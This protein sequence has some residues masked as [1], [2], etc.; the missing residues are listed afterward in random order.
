MTAVILA[1]GRGHRLRAVTGDQPKC[2]A[3]VGVRTL[4]ARQIDLIRGAGIDDIVIVAGYAYGEV[5]AAE[6]RRAQLI[7]NTRHA[8][9]NSLYSLWLARHR[10]SAGFV[11]FNCDVLLHPTLLDDL[12]TCRHD[13]AVLYAPHLPGQVYTDEEMKVQVRKGRVVTLSKALDPADADGEHL[14]LAR[15]NGSAAPLLVA[16]LACHVAAG[17]HR[18]W[19]PAAFASFAARHPLY[20]IPTR[21][22]PWIEIDSP[23]DYWQACSVVL[24]ALEDVG[25]G[26]P[27][28]TD[29]NQP[30]AK[31]SVQHV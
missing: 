22:Y 28:H 9:T 25:S 17:G 21:G 29:H 14:G 10:L 19:L 31:G 1:A 2:M 7:R 26:Q 15:F 12:L 3:R 8:T 27:A 18:K 5:A 23:E 24:P 6:G 11:V 4:L 30:S 20:A 13:A 16:E